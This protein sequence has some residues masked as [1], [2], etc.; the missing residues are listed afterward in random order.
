M[1]TE[2]EKRIREIIKEEI[3]NNP[4]VKRKGNRK[5]NKWQVFLR[6][7][8]PNQ[9]QGLS[10]GEKVKACSTQYREI[11]VKN[12]K[13]LDDMLAK[14]LE[15]NQTKNQTNQT[16]QTNQIQDQSDDKSNE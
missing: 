5:P 6:E 3:A 11:K 1:D 14:Y 7:C 10:M 16:N 2:D 9:P 8:T 12:G 15:Q 13:L 4:P